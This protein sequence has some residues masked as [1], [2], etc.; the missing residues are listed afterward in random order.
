MFSIIEEM[1]FVNSNLHTFKRNDFATCTFGKLGN[2]TENFLLYE[3]QISSV[4]NVLIYEKYEASLG[5][6]LQHLERHDSAMR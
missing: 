4:L 2:A 5:C 1:G 3:A 6:K